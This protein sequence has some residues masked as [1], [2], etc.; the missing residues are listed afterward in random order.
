[1][2]DKGLQAYIEDMARFHGGYVN[3]PNGR[4][5]GIGAAAGSMSAVVADVADVAVVAA[6]GKGAF[7][8]S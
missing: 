6:A 1:L 8:A 3:G 5:A 2:D 4:P 7:R